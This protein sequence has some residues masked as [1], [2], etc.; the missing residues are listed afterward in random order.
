[1]THLH[2]HIRFTVELS[3]EART[4]T[5]AS[6]NELH[7]MLAH[8]AGQKLATMGSD[9]LEAQIRIISDRPAHIAPFVRRRHHRLVTQRRRSA[10]LEGASKAAEERSSQRAELEVPRPREDVRLERQATHEAR[11]SSPQ[12]RPELRRS[13][14]RS[15]TTP[16]RRSA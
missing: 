8:V 9:D 7:G 6:G 15:P 13:S 11:T 2:R 14:R 12:E 1:M 5:I 10:P 3:F 4:D 16:R